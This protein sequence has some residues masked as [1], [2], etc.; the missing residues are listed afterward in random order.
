MRRLQVHTGNLSKNTHLKVRLGLLEKSVGTRSHTQNK[1]GNGEVF[2][3]LLLLPPTNSRCRSANAKTTQFFTFSNMFFPNVPFL[4][5]GPSN[6]LLK[7]CIQGVF[8]TN[9]NSFSRKLVHQLQTIFTSAD[10]LGSIPN[11]FFLHGCS[12]QIPHQ[13]F[14]KDSSVY[15]LTQSTVNLF[16]HLGM[17]RFH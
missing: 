3:P 12:L 4:S 7:I 16:Q 9:F 14:V 2:H 10:R 5:L 13:F 17:D 1:C 8:R 15:F 11:I 6:F